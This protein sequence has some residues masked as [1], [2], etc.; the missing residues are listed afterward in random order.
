VWVLEAALERGDYET[1]RVLGHNL[2]GSGKPYGS[3]ANS[4]IGGYLETAAKIR[5]TDE[6]RLQIQALG[7]FLAH[8]DSVG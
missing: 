1:L 5:S 8:P 3:V 4:R 6:I 7:D 2:K